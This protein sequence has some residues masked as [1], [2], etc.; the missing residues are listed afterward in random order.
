MKRIVLWSTSK[1][2]GTFNKGKLAAKKHESKVKTVDKYVNSK[3]HVAYKGSAN[4]KTT[5]T[6]GLIWKPN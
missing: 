4:L 1:V 6:L 2:I 3:G 5:Q